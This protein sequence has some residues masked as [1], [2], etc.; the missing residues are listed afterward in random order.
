V[1]GLRNVL[2]CLVDAA[3][4]LAPIVEDATLYWAGSGPVVVNR[5]TAPFELAVVL[6]DE[7]GALGAIE[8][9]RALVDPMRRLRVRTDPIRLGLRVCTRADRMARAWTDPADD[10]YEFWFHAKLLSGRDW[11]RGFDPA[12]ARDPFGGAERTRALAMTSLPRA[13][14]RFQ[15]QLAGT[16]GDAEVVVD[17]EPLGRAVRLVWMVCGGE[18]LASFDVALA[19]AADAL[20]G[21]LT[22]LCDRTQPRTLSGVLRT[23]RSVLHAVE[24]QLRSVAVCASEPAQVEAVASADASD[25]A[26]DAWCASQVEAGSFAPSALRA[27]EALRALLARPSPARAAQILGWAREA[28]LGEAIAALD[29][30]QD[31]ERA[32]FHDARRA[33]MAA[34]NVTGADTCALARLARVDDGTGRRS[35]AIFDAWTNLYRIVSNESRSWP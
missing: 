8:T 12:D 21:S 16:S 23:P 26:F 4:V 20:G 32:R 27:S 10:G 31:H 14:A 3:E 9:A 22:E 25:P 1:N 35:E 2:S 18:W 33:A 6:P 19:R 28:S 30:N 34:C 17:T 13:V 7:A 5:T 11:R 29:R 24:Q 15:V